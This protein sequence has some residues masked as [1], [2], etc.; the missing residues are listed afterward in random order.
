MAFTDSILARGDTFTYFYPYWHVRN[1]ALLSGQLPLWSPDLFMGVPLLANS[2]LG[3]FYPPNWIVAPLDPPDGIRV[4]I[5]LHV[6]WAA[7]GTY[8]LAKRTLG[9]GR[10][11]ALT[12]AVI[13]AFGGHIGAHVEQI[14]QLQ[15][16]AWLPW[17]IYLFDRALSRP[18][19]GTI[20][21][22][23][24]LA[25]QFFTGHTQT[26]FITGV[27]LAIYTL[28]T[29][30]VRGVITLAGAGVIALILAVPQLIPTLELTGLSNRRGGLNVNQAT[31]FSFSPFVT[32]RG[33][34]PSFDTLIFGEYVAY[35]GVI[36]LG[37]AILGALSGWAGFRQTEGLHPAPTRRRLFL[38]LSLWRGGRGVRLSPRATWLIV[39]LVGL[40]LAYGLY[41]PLYWLL[42]T[43]PGF[44][45][46]RVPARWLALFALGTAMLAGLG[47]EALITGAHSRAP[48]QPTKRDSRVGARRAAPLPWRSLRL[49]GLKN[50]LIPVLVVAALAALSLLTLRQ[51]DGTPVSLP[52]SI[53]L[54]A[55]T[56]ALIVLLIGVWRRLPL[57]LIGGVVVE[58]WLAALIMP[59][60]WLIPPDA[61]S[62]QRFTESQLLADQ[63]DQTVPGR[64]LSISGLLFDPGDRAT[65]EVRYADLPA[66]ARALAFD[67]VKLKETLGANL[68]LIWGIPSV[69]GYDG[70]VLPTADYTAFTSLLLPAGELRTVDGR[71]REILA[72]PE[73]GG[74]CIPDQRW[75]D[76]MGVRYLITDKVY[77]LVNDG[78]FYDTTFARTGEV[79]YAN[80]QA[81]V[82]TAVD[83]LCNPCD[84]L[85]VSIDG[86]DLAAGDRVSV[87]DYTRVRFAI[88]PPSAPDAVTVETGGSVRAVTLVDTRTGD[89]Q[90]LAPDPWT[91]VLSSD[92]KMY[93]NGSVL[94]RAFVVSDAAFSA[95]T[96]LGT[97]DALKLMQDPAFDPAQTVIISRDETDVLTV[98]TPPAGQTI[99][100]LP[101]E[102]GRLPKE[103]GGEVEI[104]E[105]S[106]YPRRADRHQRRARLPR[107]DRRLLSRLD[108]NRKWQRHADPA[109]RR[110]VP[111]GANPRRVE[112]GRIRVPP[113]LA[114]AHAVDRCGGVDQRL[115]R[116][117]GVQK[118]P[119]WVR[120]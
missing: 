104:T 93:A 13:F 61:Y 87:G 103:A 91:R 36:G 45:L 5:L 60:N 20:L 25:L 70:G 14:N 72:Q 90:Q 35:P 27:A 59:Y 32:G 78:V 9:V 62:G 26:V 118:T 77:D 85:R 94:P 40:A 7:L 66:E 109:R 86:V 88:D 80:R 99:P 108:S 98:E 57:L 52:T 76:L 69:D 101:T 110:D 92:I 34:L 21:L 117:A 6:A 12:A 55:W 79:T 15:G 65:L 31:A 116:A 48:L 46:F 2:Q 28:C 64:V 4:S 71:L 10:L 83:V 96:D 53:T 38:P 39:A 54:I 42:A 84:D 75:L 50:L 3:T 114:R 74:A 100:P 44:N 120:A 111:G 30:P 18:I 58:L 106:C 115:D 56:A 89:F 68:P 33:L 95:D 63:A 119:Q 43:L 67:A 81:F 107:A 8:L 19:S 113:R 16:L 105:Y 112:R 1:A 41:N 51:N 97:E 102:R 82:S 23:I 37:L 17:L 49:G 73:C 47:V 11:A 22:G 24:G 29:R